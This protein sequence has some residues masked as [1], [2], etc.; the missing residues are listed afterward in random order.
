MDPT[1][2]P[3]LMQVA[4]ASGRL[5]LGF[6]YLE[7][8]PIATQFWLY[9][10]PRGYVLKT[11]YDEEFRAYSPGTLL[12]WWM[13]ERLIT[14]EQMTCFDYLK[15]DDSYKKYWTNRRRERLNL[16]AYPH[17]MKAQVLYLVEQRALPWVRRH[18]TLAAW[19]ARLTGNG[20]GVGNSN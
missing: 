10:R 6:L 17:N 9:A 20:V 8:R 2:H 7:E 13:I 3:D 12:T 14:T 19:K 1:F 18:P 15:G 4:A 5:R 11:A 16:I